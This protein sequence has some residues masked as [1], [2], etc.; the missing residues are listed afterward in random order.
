MTTTSSALNR[1]RYVATAFAIGC[2]LGPCLALAQYP[3]KPIRFFVPIPPGGAPD[4]IARVVA[5]KLSPLLGQPVVVETR[6]GSGGNIATDLVARAAP[7]GY[8]VMIAYD[9]MIVINPHMYANMT[10]D[11]MKDLLPIASMA[12]ARSM[13][14]VVNPSLPVKDLKDFIEYAKKA[15]PP[16]AFASGGS[17]SQHQMSME[18]LKSRAGIN[19][20]HVPYK[21]GAPAAT[22]VM[23]GEVPVMFAGSVNA[24]QVRAGKLRLLGVTGESRLPI[25]P[26]VPAIGELYPGYLITTWMGMFGP[27]GMP[28]PVTARLRADTRRALAMPEVRERIMTA[29]SL[30]TY[31]ATPEE[32]SSV[33]RADY[34][35]YGKLVK[36]FGIKAD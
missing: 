14:L 4:I 20:L 33:I 9:A 36:Q 5:D 23:G 32:F 28:E 8:T 18:L 3:V 7:D 19:L 21:G 16:L 22:A 35:K 6:A 31:N 24:T 29:S 12:V 30:E 25:F 17:G 27:A 26:D 11:P 34:E 13:L 2:L 1:A 10:V 15:N